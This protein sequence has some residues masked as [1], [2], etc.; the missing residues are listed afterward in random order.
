MH[1]HGVVQESLIKTVVKHVTHNSK[2]HHQES[3]VNKS[4]G[5]CT[6]VQLFPLEIYL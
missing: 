4:L 6:L 3:F 5:I 1:V 2:F